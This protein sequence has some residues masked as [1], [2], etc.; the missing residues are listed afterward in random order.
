M[1]VMLDLS[2]GIGA[3]KPQG[4]LYKLLRKPIPINPRVG[5]MMGVEISRSSSKCG[6]IRHLSE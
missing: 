4:L 1:V 3:A 2:S 5:D 6:S